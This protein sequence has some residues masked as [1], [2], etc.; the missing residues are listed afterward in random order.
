MTA[1]RP[2]P[3]LPAPRPVPAEGSFQEVAI[4]DPFS[5]SHS[6]RAEPRAALSSGH[7]RHRPGA[8]LGEERGGLGA[9]GGS[10]RRR[11]EERCPALCNG[12]GTRAARIGTAG[13]AGLCLLREGCASS[14]ARWRLLRACSYKNLFPARNSG[15]PKRGLLS[16]MLLN[17]WERRRFPDR[18]RAARARP[19]RPS[20]CG[21]CLPAASNCCVPPGPE[22]SISE[23]HLQEWS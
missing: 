2:L 9:A 7:G 15:A 23:L 4:L 18:R 5:R 1:R 3:P 14:A 11:G 10:R 20:L 19:C 8:L 22:V 16:V 6:G 12:G 13:C 21:C 17:Q